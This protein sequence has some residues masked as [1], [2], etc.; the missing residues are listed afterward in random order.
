MIIQ[1]LVLSALAVFIY[2]KGILDL[3]G[4]LAAILIG[5]PIIFLAGAQ[6]FTLLLLFL[7]VS[8]AATKYRFADKEKLKVAEASRGK[9]N[10]INV[11]ANGLI[12]A[13]FA[14]LLCYSSSFPDSVKALT[15]AGY[16]AAIATVTGDTLSSEIGVLSKHEPFLI[17]SFKKVPRGTHGGISPLGETVGL[18]GTLAIGLASWILGVV[19]L[20]FAIPVAVIG[21]AIG[22][23]FDSFLGATLERRGLC[24]NAT[25]NFLST[26]A[27]AIAGLGL[28]SAL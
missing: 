18:L 15:L 17:T 27:G 19:S 21:G 26:T 8:Y 24:G 3:R 10:A 7:F 9:R 12:P 23:H 14:F 28:A 16:I 2:T 20:S 13:F 25:V 5:G 6:W 1:I 11:L 22:F 4:T